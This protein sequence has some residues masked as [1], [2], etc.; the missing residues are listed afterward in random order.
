MTNK[1]TNRKAIG[2]VLENC[3]IPE[4]VRE[5]LE[6]IAASLE[7]KSSPANRKPTA[8]QIENAGFKDTILAFMRE[9][10]NRLFTC[11][12]LGKCVPCLEGM[13]SQRISALVNSLKADE[14]VI[15]V[16]DKGR[17]YFKAAP[18]EN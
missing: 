12:E 2:Y 11:T 1:M 6:S 17:S 5:K 3:E 8:K 7:K 13:Q 10:P 16:V 18:V 14:L 15:K 4:D 9:D